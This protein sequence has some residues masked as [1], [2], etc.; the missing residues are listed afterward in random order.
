VTGYH[1][2]A[3]VGARRIEPPDSLDFFPTPLWGTRA[4][5][6][7]IL[8]PRRPRA[9]LAYLTAWD[10]ACGQG[11][12]VRALRDDFGVVHGSDIFPYGFGEMGDFLQTPLLGGWRPPAHPDWIITNPPFN[13]AM[14]FAVEAMAQ[15]RKGVALL[16]RLQWME[17]QPR[18]KFFRQYPCSY[19]CPFIGRLAMVKGRVSRKAKSATA[20]AWFVWDFEDPGAIDNERIIR[21]PFNA[22]RLL[23]RPT[24][25]D[26]T[27]LPL[28]A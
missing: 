19:I 9:A 8:A 4:L 25:W 15:A 17:T 10:P 18:E 20:Y 16:C 14:D 23:E 7:F 26:E 5:S 12:M 1:V 22:R 21:I 2:S 6:R 11:H 28:A 13:R 24:D 27:P 3:A